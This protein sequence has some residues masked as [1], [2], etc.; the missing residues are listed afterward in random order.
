MIKVT[1]ATIADK[2]NI[3]FSGTLV[4]NGTALCCVSFTGENTEI[5]A[6]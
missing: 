6:I 4:N 3:V 5:G 1:K 2:S